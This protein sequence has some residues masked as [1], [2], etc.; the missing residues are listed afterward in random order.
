VLHSYFDVLSAITF[1]VHIFLYC[2]SLIE[3]LTKLRNVTISF[4]MYVCPSV[5][6]EQLGSQWTAFLEILYLHI[7]RK[8]L[9]K[10]QVSL[11][12]TIVTDILREDQV[13]FLDHISL[14]SSSKDK[15][16][17]LSL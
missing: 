2:V 6:L 14:S 1:V 9:H 15:C 16:V 11:H 8:F 17:T 5:R 7:F 3:F 10:I 4:V 12:L 13:N